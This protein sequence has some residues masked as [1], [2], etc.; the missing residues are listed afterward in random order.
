MTVFEA[1]NNT[2]K[3]LFAAGIDDYVFEAKQIIK[4]I[5]GYSNQEVLMHYASHL[6]QYQQNNLTALIKQRIVRYPLQYIFGEWDFYGCTF[7]VGPGV[8]VPRA[9][10]ETLV[11]KAVEFLKE[12]ENAKALDLCSGSGCVG[13]AIAKQLPDADVVLLEKYDEAMRYLEKNITLNKAENVTA[14][15]GDIFNGDAA[16]GRYD[17]IVSNPPYIPSD[18]METISPETHFEPENALFGGEDGMMF[19]RAITADY[20]KSLKD[21]GMLAFEVGMGESDSVE[22]IMSEN[23]F[24]NIGTVC[25]LSGIKRVV[26]GTA[27]NIK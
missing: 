13:I 23:G 22:K 24:E 9:D 20:K 25:D 7:K 26:F 12:R 18:E 8:L 21:G 17:I 14:V 2:K 11:E 10:T 1:Y 4:H 5:T 6:T 15:K 27:N 16:D 3:E 19:Y